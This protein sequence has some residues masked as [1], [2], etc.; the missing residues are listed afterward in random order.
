[1]II[2]FSKKIISRLIV[3][4]LIPLRFKSFS[5]STIFDKIINK[6]II[7]DIVYEDKEVL[8][9][10]DINPVAP[11]HILII[12][13]VK[14]GLSGISKAEEKN[15]DILG[16]LLLTAKKIGDQLNIKDGYRLV[17]NEGV[18]GG[19]TVYHI[20]IHFLAG[21]QFDSPGKEKSPNEN[22]LI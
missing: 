14:N 1:M 3:K 6:E 15:V 13:K 17:I 2:T 7:A 4:H 9:F 10:K 18:N 22:K 8:A 16:Q 21:K 20:H 19:Q 11:I 12:P 5:S